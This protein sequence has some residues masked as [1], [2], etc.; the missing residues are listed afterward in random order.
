MN[1][2]IS[3]MK[4]SAPATMTVQQFRKEFGHKDP[5]KQLRGKANRDLGK[6]FEAMVDE[7]CEYYRVRDIADI[8]KTP[9]PLRVI[10]ALEQGRFIACFDK[11]AQPDYKGVVAQSGRAIAFEAKHSTTGRIEKSRVTQE[12]TKALERFW[13]MGAH[14][15]VL[16]GFDMNKFYRVPWEDWRKMKYIF[17][18]KYIVPEDIVVF[19]LRTSGNVL[20]FMDL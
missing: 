10:K 7:S 13:S 5:R 4:N 17:G 9:E 12:Q 6:Q 11:K 20:L 3:Y 1:G 16:V 14:C 18:R 15:F 2:G 8:E 19:S